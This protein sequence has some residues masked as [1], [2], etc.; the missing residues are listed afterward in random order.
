MTLFRRKSVVL[1]K[2]RRVFVIK[3][4]FH[5]RVIK[6]LIFYTSKSYK[7]NILEFKDRQ[8]CTWAATD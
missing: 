2:T 4:N 8:T 5:R 6:N 1:T 3:F 7:F